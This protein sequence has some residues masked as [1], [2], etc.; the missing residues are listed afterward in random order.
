MTKAGVGSIA[1]GVV[2]YLLAGQTQIG[3]LYLFDAVIWS[4]VLLSAIIPWWSLK[5]LRIKRRVRVHHP[6]KG[7]LEQAVPTED[8]TVEIELRVENRGRLARYFVK[9]LEECPLEEPGKGSRTFLLPTV[10]PGS[11]LAFSYTATC[12]KRG[13]YA[14]AT[15]VLETSGPLGLFV[16]RRRFDVPLNVTVYPL[17]YRM[18][19]MLTASEVPMYQE[20]AARIRA[21]SQ[22]YGSREYQH[23]DP[24]RHIHWRNTARLGELVVKQFEEASL[25]SVAVAFEAGRDWGVGRETT[26]EY[27]IKIAASLAMDCAGSGRSI[28]LL[29]GP[30]PLYG[31]GWLEAMD[32]LS[33]LSEGRGVALS[34]LA[35]MAEANQPLLVVVTARDTHLLPGLIGLALDRPLTVM[36]L[37]EFAPAERPQEFISQLTWRGIGLVRCSRGHLKEAIEELSGSM[38]LAG[39]LPSVV[40]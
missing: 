4:L 7:R 5:P 11:D 34:E 32:Y 24:L 38:A 14:S 8:D 17:Y 16:R 30:S 3:W 39:Q 6:S 13:R 27:S 10:K 35:T 12:Y 33:G 36:L 9:V 37:E 29:T 28:D 40:G 19:G 25:G 2:V 26:L 1:G 23:G 20:G 21:A 31:A 18:S 15:A 22:F